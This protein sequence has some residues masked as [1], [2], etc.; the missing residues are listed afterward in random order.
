MPASTEC[1]Q[2]MKVLVYGGTGTQARPTVEHLLRRH[3][4]PYVLTRNPENAEDLAKLGAT[5]VTADL[6][7][8]DLLHT[9]SDKV[10]AVAFLLPA[11]LD[12]PED[13]L[14]L[15]RNAVDA[16]KSAGV[17]LFV[18]NASGEIPDVEDGVDTKC[19]LLNYLHASGVPN[20]VFEPTTYMENWLGPWTAPSVLQNGE[21]TYPVL[22]DRKMGWIACDDVGALVVAALERPSL[23]GS[24][25]RISGVETPTGP[26]LAEIFAAACQK[27]VKYRT[28]SPEEMGQV[29]DS[30]FG[31]GAGDGVAEMYRRE[32]NDPYPT[33]KFHDMSAVLDALPVK[34]TTIREWVEAHK[35]SFV[36]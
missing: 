34:M 17:G 5:L 19:D 4:E 15:G 28:M 23:A 26:E 24:H 16:A 1:T 21:L 32:Q 10:D 33:P 6:S 22:H 20:I 7:D 3:H 18:W 8:V 29:L 13:G 27:P 36:A 2:P 12:N 31:S 30:L 25:Y 11:F 35:D 14:Q 9:A